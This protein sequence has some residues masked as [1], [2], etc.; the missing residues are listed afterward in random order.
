MK[1]AAENVV[2][3]I[4]FLGLGIFLVWLITHHL[5]AEQWIRIKQVFLTA[6][7]WVLLPVFIIGIISHILRALRWRMLIEPMGYRPRVFTTFSAVM[8]GYL[9]NLALPRM[10]EITRCGVLS[11]HENIPFQKVIGTMIVERGIDVL[12]LLLV[13]I[14]SVFIQIDV[15]GRFFYDMV[16][17]KLSPLFHH[18]SWLRYILILIIIALVITGL[19]FLLRLFR[20]TRWYRKL[21]IMLRGIKEGMFTIGKM[22]KKGLFFIYTVVIWLCY[23][24]MVYVGF[25]C[26]KP[27]SVLGIKAGLSVLG[28]G[29]IGMVLTQGG[30]GAYQLIV[31]KTLEL[32]GILEA[33]GFAF[34]WLSWIT[35]TL[36]TLVLGLFC[37][38]TLPFMKRKK[39]MLSA[40]KAA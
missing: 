16:I 37:T 11:R 8:I 29:S 9:A 24:L 36:L 10:G 3:L 30:I 40:E 26:L 31:E 14:A 6:N 22:K 34:G 4:V 15:V 25:F 39:V 32:Y 7:Y 13:I 21:I 23:F 1:K 35:Q 33:Y 28:F 27:T 20:H 5:T 12:C 17:R 19:I 18:G 38:I 2:K